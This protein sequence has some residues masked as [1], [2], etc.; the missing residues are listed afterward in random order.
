MYAPCSADIESNIGAT[1]EITNIDYPGAASTPE[2]IPC[3]GGA[4]ES[5]TVAGGVNDFGV[6]TGHFWDTSYNEHGF[7][8]YPNGT[9]V[10]VDYPGASQTG[11]AEMNDLGVMVG[12]YDD[13]SFVEHGYILNTF[14]TH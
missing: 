1:H 9:W 3:G 6:V 4:T 8:H 12:H 2:A 7:I 11:G 10:Q 5:G 14:R 13:S